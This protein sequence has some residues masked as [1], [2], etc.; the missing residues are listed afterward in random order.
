M[1]GFWGTPSS[2]LPA[3]CEWYALEGV[4]DLESEHLSVSHRSASE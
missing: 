4:L 1:L 3:L 2:S